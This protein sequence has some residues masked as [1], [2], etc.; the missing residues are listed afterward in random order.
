M[1]HTTKILL[2]AAI[3]LALMA[4]CGGTTVKRVET[5]STIDLSGGWNDAD[6][7]M[8]AED[9]I[10]DCMANPWLGQFQ[11]KTP[12]VIVGEI[13]NKSHEI[14]S[15]ETFSKELERSLISSGK[16]KFV[17]SQT[18]RGQL[19]SEKQDMEENAS[20][21]TMKRLRMETGADLMLIGGINTIVDQEGK[22]SV[23]YYQVN[24][25]LINIESNV[26]V[27]IGEKKIKKLVTR[28]KTKL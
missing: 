15:T 12:V 17:A 8:T 3:G 25:E 11:G 10:K 26:K 21:E 6:S 2:I 22:K 28:S 19:R 23:I 1:K 13:R 5:D 24:L 4:G 27:W 20:P 7:R 9:M 16:V 14:I 18:E